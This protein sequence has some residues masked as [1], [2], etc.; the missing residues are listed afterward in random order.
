[1]SRTRVATVALALALSGC[2]DRPPRPDPPER[3]ASPPRPPKP[4][5]DAAALE[6]SDAGDLDAAAAAKQLVVDLRASKLDVA[7]RRVPTQRLAFGK[8]RLA[9]LTESELLVRDT[10]DMKELARLPV[11]QPRRLAALQDGSLLVAGAGEVWHVP[12]DPKKAQRYS[13]LPLFPDSLLL[14]DRREKKRLWVHHGID[15]TLYPYELGEAGRLETLD[16]IELK[17][18][19]Q[20]GFALLKDG[21]YVYTAGAKL[22]RFFPGGKQWSLAL[23]PGGEVWRILTT[24]R[25]DEIWLARSDGK[26]VLTQLS[27]AALTVKK[28]LDV[29]GTFDVATNDTAVA[30]LSLTTSA[31][32]KDAPAD[33]A[34][35]ARSWRLVVR[36]ADGKEQ[37]A[38]ELPLDPATSDE[39]WVRELTKNR[40]VV[41]SASQPLVAVGGP[42]WLGAWNYK[43]GERVLAP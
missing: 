35:P 41:L 11:A 6:L 4:D 2:E 3:P 43:T 7:P 21:S 25:L 14:G 39:D 37:M 27:D 1:M 32:A 20:K 8:D 31:A 16:F 28:T 9:Q 15:P 12:K 34:P 5:L 38:T 26:L 30:L 17:E 24:Q 36:D 23:P 13:R 40:A 10:K 18:A 29:P 22:Q 33:A 19:D 42:S